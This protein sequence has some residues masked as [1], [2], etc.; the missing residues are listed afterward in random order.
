M[1]CA[2]YCCLLRHQHHLMPHYMNALVSVYV[3]CVQNGYGAT[4]A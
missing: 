3:Y 2:S 4:N 1:V